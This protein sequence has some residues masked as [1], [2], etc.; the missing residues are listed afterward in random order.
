MMITMLLCIAVNYY[1]VTNSQ[2][3]DYNVTIY[4]SQYYNVTNSQ[5]DD[6][7]VTRDDNYNVTVIFSLP[8]VLH[9]R[10]K[11]YQGYTGLGNNL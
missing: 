3:D 1:N 6:Y 9:S 10:N 7:N 5:Y 2:Y 8:V 11:C 4:S